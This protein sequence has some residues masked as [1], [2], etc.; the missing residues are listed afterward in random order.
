MKADLLRCRPEEALVDLGATGLHIHVFM[1]SLHTPSI[2]L[3]VCIGIT[4]AFHQAGGC[5]DLT[6]SLVACCAVVATCQFVWWAD[7]ATPAVH[8]QKLHTS[9]SKIFTELHY[10]KTSLLC[11][12]Y[13]R[14]HCML[15]DALVVRSVQ[16]A[17]VHCAFLNMRPG[18]G[19]TL[20]V[21]QA[22]KW[23]GSSFFTPPMHLLYNS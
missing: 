12:K 6:T 22:P 2:V 1:V 23:A 9:Y 17:F 13:S 21:V 3:L 15:Q 10:F 11:W 4:Y 20:K 19:K 7:T 18:H 8:Q 5:G 16:A 14:M